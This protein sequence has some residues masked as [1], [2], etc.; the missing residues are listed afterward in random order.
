MIAVIDY[1]KGNIRSVVRGLEGAGADVVV[2]DSPDVLERVKAI[3]LPGVGAFKD[4][5]TSL[6]ELGLVEP[7]V[8]SIGSGVPYLGICLG[9]HVLFEGG[10][11]HSQDGSPHDG[12]GILPG[13]VDRLPAEGYGEDGCIR[14][15][16]LP[17]VGWNTVDVES[18][19]SPLLD[20]LEDGEH[21]YF[22]HSYASPASPFTIAETTHSI[23]FPSVVRKGDAWG[24]QFHPEKSSMAGAR[25]LE[26]FVRA[27]G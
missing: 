27:Y 22:T 6:E 16:K 15:F 2:T 12:L 21:F 14:R 9:M 11:E 26:N 24:V 13:I 17:H 18:D 1:R 23:P 3:V 10:L 19:P 25:L 8:E 5:M 4:A 20:R 7:I